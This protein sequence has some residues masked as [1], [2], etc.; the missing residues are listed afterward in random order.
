MKLFT[1]NTKIILFAF[2]VLLVGTAKV[3]AQRV[4]RDTVLI[5]TDSIKPNGEKN[6]RAGWGVLI[7]EYAK[8]QYAGSMALISVGG[9]WDYGKNKH[10]ETDVFIGFLP[11]YSTSKNKITFTVKQ[12]YIPWRINAGPRFTIEPL[13]TGLYLNSIWGRDF[14]VAEPE[15]YPNSYYAFSSKIRINIF[16]GQRVT[17]NFEKQRD[18][19]R[20]ASFFYE[21]STNDLYLLSAVKNSYLKPKDYLVLSLG[22]KLQMF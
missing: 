16:A 21:V 8:I 3:S 7:P 22:V 11:H 9:G 2:F 18:F 4:I 17:Y 15:K 14:W 12:N 13:T 5:I 19:F 6:Y 1:T 10:W 20:S